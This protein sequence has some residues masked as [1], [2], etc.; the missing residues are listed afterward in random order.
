M[1]IK[2]QPVK[3]RVFELEG[4]AGEILFSLTLKTFTVA[5]LDELAAREQ[6]YPE[7]KTMAES[8]ERMAQYCEDFT[9]EKKEFFRRLD[10]VNAMAILKTVADMVGK[11]DPEEK[12]SQSGE[13]P[14]T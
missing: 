8:V 4:E 13:N 11:K 12:K 2:F 1:K 10:M 7:P 9:Q 14:T 5:E 3:K 6:D